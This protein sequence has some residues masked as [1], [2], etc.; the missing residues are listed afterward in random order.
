MFSRY[1]CYSS[2]FLSCFTFADVLV[3]VAPIMEP[4]KFLAPSTLPELT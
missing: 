4:R 2:F 1:S 3:F